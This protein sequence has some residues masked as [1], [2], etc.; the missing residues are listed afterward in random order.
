[1]EHKSQVNVAYRPV[2]TV[3]V[4]WT[5]RRRTHYLTMGWPGRRPPYP[6]TF[7]SGSVTLTAGGSGGS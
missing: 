6:G 5:W 2:F 4:H 3:A 1:M 7:S